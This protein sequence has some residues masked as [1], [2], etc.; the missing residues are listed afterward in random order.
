MKNE[1]IEIVKLKSK[2]NNDFTHGSHNKNYQN[3][4]E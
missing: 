2:N 3:L 4:Y 1:T